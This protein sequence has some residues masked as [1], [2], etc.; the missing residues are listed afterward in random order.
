MRNR[1]VLFFGED[2]K[3]NTKIVCVS[4]WKLDF[5]QMCIV[6]AHLWKLVSKA[7]KNTMSHVFSVLFLFLSKYLAH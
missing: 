6:Y 4:G 5:Q 2:K 7:E 3:K 1:V